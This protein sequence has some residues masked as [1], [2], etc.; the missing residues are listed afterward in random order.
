MK[1]RILNGTKLVPSHPEELTQIYSISRL[2]TYNK[3]DLFKCVFQWVLINL[4]TPIT[5]TTIKIYFHNPKFSWSISITIHHRTQELERIISFNAIT[6]QKSKLR[7]RSLDDVCKVRRLINYKCRVKP[8]IPVFSPLCHPAC[9]TRA[10]PHIPSNNSPTV[11]ETLPG[12]A[13][14]DHDDTVPVQLLS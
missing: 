3:T 11:E 7:S 5:T 13:H 8:G 6:F 4:Y 14:S 2:L 1:E 10:S 9:A 12:R